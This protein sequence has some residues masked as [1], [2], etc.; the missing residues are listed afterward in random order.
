MQRTL[1]PELKY[2]PKCGDEYRAEITVCAVCA[3]YLISGMKLLDLR[4]QEERKLAERRR[5]ISPDDELVSIQ[6]GPVVQM[7]MVQAVLKKANIPSLA[8][9]DSG[10][11]CASGGCSGPNLLIQVRRSDLED[12]RTVLTEN[13]IRST[14]LHDHDLSAVDA[15]FDA[16][17]E[18]ALCPACGCRFS[19]TQNSCPDCGLCFA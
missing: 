8:A 9:G 13:Y 15:V 3:V 1:E 10:A 12:A 6:K 17:A 5:P 18:Y 2:C 19:T 16:E 11:S 14:G 7:Q 4:R